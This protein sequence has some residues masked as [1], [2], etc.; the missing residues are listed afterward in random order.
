[1]LS[2]EDIAVGNR[3]SSFNAEIRILKRKK[4]LVDIG[5][6]FA[7]VISSAL[8]DV[9]QKKMC[10]DF[11]GSSGELERAVRD[12]FDAVDVFKDDNDY[13]DGDFINPSKI[14]A[15]MLSVFLRLHKSGHL[16]TLFSFRNEKTKNTYSDFCFYYFVYFCICSFLPVDLDDIPRDMER[17]FL[18]CMYKD[19][20]IAAHWAAWGMRGFFDAYSDS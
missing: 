12:Y 8:S 10:V 6:E 18:V 5:N 9:H 16:G 1:M 7:N 3:I 15:F 14:C 4:A 20:G 17:D 13:E 2:R 19:E 11:N